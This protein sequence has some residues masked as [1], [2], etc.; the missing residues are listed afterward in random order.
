MVLIH[1]QN[2]ISLCFK[3]NSEEIFLLL[4]YKKS[5]KEEAVTKT[6]WSAMNYATVAESWTL[7]LHDEL[8]EE[9]VMSTEITI[10][11]IKSWELA[12]PCA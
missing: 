1:S 4:N 11:N 9:L 12:V 8:R 5:F 10:I 7:C 2:N 6:P 3:C